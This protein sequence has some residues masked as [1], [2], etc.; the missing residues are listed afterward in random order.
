LKNALDRG[1][2]D[3]ERYLAEAAA[4]VGRREAGR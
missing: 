3:A 2:T 4:A 1:A